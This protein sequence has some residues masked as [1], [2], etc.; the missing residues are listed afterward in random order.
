MIYKETAESSSMLIDMKMNYI[1]KFDFITNTLSLEYLNSDLYMGEF[2]AFEGYEI[3][4]ETSNFN[5]EGLS[6][7]SN[8]HQ[9]NSI[10]DIKKEKSDKKRKLAYEGVK[11]VSSFVPVLN[12][13]TALLDI[14]SYTNEFVNY[15]YWVD[16]NISDSKINYYTTNK[17]FVKENE[18]NGILY[19]T[20]LK[21]TGFI[22]NYYNYYDNCDYLG[23]DNGSANV[24]NDFFFWKCDKSKF[25]EEYMIRG[26]EY[27]IYLKSPYVDM[28]LVKLGYINKG[29]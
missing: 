16:E 26:L 22:D 7:Y 6:F 17:Y 10:A 13:I 5:L 8:L 2:S 24:K 1:Y 23:S 28:P 9:G 4:D 11:L 15:F 21:L 29:E 20:N 25:Y 14:M 3:C 19:N 27:Y 12:N 18:H